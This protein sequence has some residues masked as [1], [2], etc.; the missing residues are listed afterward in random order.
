MW[1]MLLLLTE[2]A[3]NNTFTQL[4][5]VLK[6]PDDLTK[7]RKIFKHFQ[8]VFTENNAAVRLSSESSDVF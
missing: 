2:G 3:T 8:R 7:T 4:A 5:R 6:L 1:S